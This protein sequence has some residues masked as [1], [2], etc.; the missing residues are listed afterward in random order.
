MKTSRPPLIFFGNGPLAATTL[1]ILSK[2]YKILFIARSRQDLETVKSLK[3]THPSA[4]GVLASF[5]HLI[6]PDLLSL[7][8]PTGIL[9]LH[10]SLLPAY[11][12]PSPI[13]TAIL[14]GDK[15]FSFSI[16]KL[17]KAMDAGPVYHQATLSPSD[18][19]TSLPPKAEVYARLATAGANWLVEHLA[20]L[21]LPFEQNHDKATY[22]TKLSKDFSP[23]DPSTKTAAELLNQI[24]AFAD[25]P[26]SRYRFNQV[27]CI[28]LSAHLGPKPNTS[29]DLLCVDGN[30]LIIDELQPLSRKAMT[31]AAFLNGYRPH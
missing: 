21:P 17:A 4:L 25:F 3:L 27:P 7:F 26:K 13:E 14:N 24:R 8:E 10:P 9:N 18:F 11:R 15:E 20:N 22:T 12:G 2:H 1:D 31:A 29:L 6:K 19:S 16:M 28:V 23:L 5:G 30:Y